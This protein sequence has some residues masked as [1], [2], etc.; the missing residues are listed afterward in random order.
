MKISNPAIRSSLDFRK[1]NRSPAIKLDSSSNN[2]E[3]RRQAQKRQTGR[4]AAGAVGQI[5]LLLVGRRTFGMT[6]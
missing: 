4:A 5:P 6:R 2:Q 3:L 1:R